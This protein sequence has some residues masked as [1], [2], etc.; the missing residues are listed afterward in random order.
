MPDL[1]CLL[2]GGSVGGAALTCRLTKNNRAGNR[3]RTGLH[4]DVTLFR[5]RSLIY[6]I[7]KLIGLA[8]RADPY[9][10]HSIK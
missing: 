2:L 8:A 5:F 4:A 10:T 3:L 1:A 6:K 7:I 9:F